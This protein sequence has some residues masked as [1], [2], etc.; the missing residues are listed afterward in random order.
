MKRILLILI[1]TILLCLAG[2]T[3]IQAAT[4]T[5]LVA[6]VNS[7]N[8]TSY[9]STYFT[10]ASNDLLVVKVIASNSTSTGTLTS[11]EGLGFTRITSLSYASFAH[12]VYL[13]V[14]N[15]LASNTSQTVTFDCS[16]DQ[17]TGAIIFVMGV[18]GMSRTGSSAIRQSQVQSGTSGGTP[19]P[20]FSSSALTGNPTVG[21]VANGTNPAGMTEPT[22]WT[23]ASD[24]EY[25]N[26]NT[27]GEYVSR[28]SGFTGTQ[29]T[30]GSSSATTSWGC[31]IAEL[32]TSAASSPPPP[33]PTLH[34]RACGRF[35]IGR[36]QGI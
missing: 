19:N 11:S 16:D 20:S 28:D 35:L 1:A 34:E 3:S 30:W 7:G 22:N 17:A 33:R 12:T 23:E 9:P 14:A 10:P 21:V 32:D 36:K 25:A 29:I 2:P 27:G 13:F 18:S 24:T 31:I 4:V 15:S 26:P 5:H 6:T 8:V